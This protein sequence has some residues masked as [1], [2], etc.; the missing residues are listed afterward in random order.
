MRHHLGNTTRRNDTV[1]W[2]MPR[3]DRNTT[4]WRRTNEGVSVKVVESR[5]SI[6]PKEV[7]RSDLI[8]YLV[9][10]DLEVPLVAISR[11]SVV[12][13]RLEIQTMVPV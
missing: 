4:V 3:L 2:N 5:E 6:R 12:S 8:R 11:V 10:I 13:H 9:A 7:V 1:A